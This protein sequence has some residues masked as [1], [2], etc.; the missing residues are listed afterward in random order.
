[1]PAGLSWLD[2]LGTGTAFGLVFAQGFICCALLCVLE[3]MALVQ[4]LS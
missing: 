2:V 3:G 1:M 4:A